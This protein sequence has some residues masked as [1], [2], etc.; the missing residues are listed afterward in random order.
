MQTHFQDG[1]FSHRV[2]RDELLN[3]VAVEIATGGDWQTPARRL[4]IVAAYGYLCS[5]RGRD[6]A[7]SCAEDLGADLF[8]GFLRRAA[9]DV[10]A[11][12]ERWLRRGG[13]MHD[14]ASRVC[15][16]VYVP[17][18]AAG[19]GVR[20]YAASDAVLDYTIDEQDDV[21]RGAERSDIDD[22]LARVGQMTTA[23][24]RAVAVE[25]F[26]TSIMKNPNYIK[27]LKAKTILAA[28]AKRDAVSN[29]VINPEEIQR[30]TAELSAAQ[31]QLTR[32]QGSAEKPAA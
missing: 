17:H 10:P 2:S 29:R 11:A 5:T 7:A 6:V 3:D 22:V 23:Q 28:I 31:A 26:G 9:E 13:A 27:T 8:A 24:F 30:R 19:A 1:G 4:C 20:A 12:L 32:E 16:C 21:R 18:D 14:A 15:E 25:L